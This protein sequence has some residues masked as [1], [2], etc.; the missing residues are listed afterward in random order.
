MSWALLN[1]QMYSQRPTSTQSCLTSARK[2]V[3][4]TQSYTCT[5][6]FSRST[7]RMSV[8]DWVPTTR[9]FQL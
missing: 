5:K 7:T 6:T 1:W 4:T 8:G 9:R 3:E 2:I